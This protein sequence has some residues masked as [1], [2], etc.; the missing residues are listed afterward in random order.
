MFKQGNISSWM[1][2]MQTS[3]PTFNQTITQIHTA[4]IEAIRELVGI[5]ASVEPLSGDIQFV[6]PNPQFPPVG[7]TVCFTY[8]VPMLKLPS[9]TP[10]AIE[11]DSLLLAN[12]VCQA[13]P[14]IGTE[15]CI[16]IS[17]QR[18]EV[19]FKPNQQLPVGMFR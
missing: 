4:V 5:D 16:T 1:Y 14:Q 18:G 17:V 9:A 10:E 19:I 15:D 8:Q 12:K 7:A 11:H 3:L 6:Q 13:L 2:A